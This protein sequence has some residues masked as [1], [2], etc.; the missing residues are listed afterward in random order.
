M[1]CIFVNN[2]NLLFTKMRYKDTTFFYT[3]DMLVILYIL[4]SNK[5][6]RTEISTA[7]GENYLKLNYLF[8]F[9]NSCMQSTK[10]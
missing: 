6:S 5:K 1:L 9:S 4:Y 8:N 2:K 7:L 10:A 3:N